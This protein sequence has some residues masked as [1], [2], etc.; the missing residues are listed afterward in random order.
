MK[1]KLVTSEPAT[2]LF[3]VSRLMEMDELEAFAG[4]AKANAAEL[5]ARGEFEVVVAEDLAGWLFPA[6]EKGM[7]VTMWVSQAE[8][9]AKRERKGLARLFGGRQARPKVKRRR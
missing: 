3:V 4:R 1:V 9:A 8:L 7:L 6:G 2:G 5:V